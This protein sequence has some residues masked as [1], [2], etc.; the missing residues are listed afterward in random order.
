[1]LG[2]DAAGSLEADTD[3]YT[4]G[5]GA[6]R[7]ELTARISP[8]WFCTVPSESVT[9]D[10]RARNVTSVT[11]VSWSGSWSCL[12]LRGRSS[13]CPEAVGEMCGGEVLSPMFPI[14]VMDSALLF[15]V[16][17]D[18]HASQAN[19]A[20]W[21]QGSF[22]PWAGFVL[23]KYGKVTNSQ[24]GREECWGRPWWREA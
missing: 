20:N 23:S 14:Y 24:Q 8:G 5:T 18:T 4:V 22:K 9:E 1:M 2:H 12:R 10:I 16:G 3:F 19:M 21:V 15:S 6:H 7:N 11:P 17:R 13:G